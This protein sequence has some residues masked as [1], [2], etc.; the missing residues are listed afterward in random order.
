M[1]PRP[2]PTSRGG[3]TPGTAEIIVNGER[4]TVAT[5]TYRKYHAFRFSQRN[6]LVTVIGLNYQTCLRS[7]PSPTWNPICSRPPPPGAH[8]SN[9]CGTA[10]PITLGQPADDRHQVTP[11]ARPSLS[12][13][14]SDI[15]AWTSE[16]ARI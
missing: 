1:A 6:V 7:H 10:L 14:G 3:F 11:S 2:L 9:N 15:E 13:T 5:L 12:I 4:R 8:Y 16:N